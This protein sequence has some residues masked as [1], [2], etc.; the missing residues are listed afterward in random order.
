[1]FAPNVIWRCATVAP[2]PPA[3]A[4]ADATHAVPAVQR[5]MT[6]GANK[7]NYILYNSDTNAAIWGDGTDGTS[8][9]VGTGTGSDVAL[10]LAGTI[11]GGQTLLPAGAYTDTVN[12]SV[13]Y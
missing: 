2:A 8:T 1:M 5:Q 10:T 3:R 9:I 12:V 7:L 4:S 6:F 13:V 11:P